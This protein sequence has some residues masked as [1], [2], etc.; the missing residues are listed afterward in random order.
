MELFKILLILHVTGGGFS[1][2]V[3]TYILFIKKGDKRHKL[4]G[5]VYF[6]SMLTAA[7]VSLPMAILHPNYFLFIVGIF[8]AYMLLSGRRYLQI[9]HL[10][11]VK[12]TDWS[13]ALVMLIFG[14]TFIGFGIYNI[15]YGYYFGIVFLVFGMISLLF[16]YQDYVNYKGKSK[17]KNYW[18][19]THIQRM[20]GSYIASVTAF[21]VVNNTILNSTIAWLL[22]TVILTPLIILW[23]KRNIILK[24]KV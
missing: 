11:H 15:I 1:L 21:L 20:M 22:P 19:T 17:F 3:G 9:K 7:L 5:N 16:V 14:T 6:Y 10:D 12:T 8:T 2:L 23:T 18:L 24:E 13:L 4:L